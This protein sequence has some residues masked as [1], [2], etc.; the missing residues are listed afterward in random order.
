MKTVTGTPGL[1]PNSFE[2]GANWTRFLR[3]IDERR[4]QQAVESMTRMLGG[5]ALPGDLARRLTHAQHDHHDLSLATL[6]IHLD[7]RNCLEVA[8]L[9]GP[10]A[11]VRAFADGVTTQRGVHYGSLHILPI[12]G[13]AHAR[14][15]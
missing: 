3:T 13:H 6:H 10:A 4:V 12:E 9:R 15:P 14:A 2:F 5:E 1:A 8:V 11:A 7:Q